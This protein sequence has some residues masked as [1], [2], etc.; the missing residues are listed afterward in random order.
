MVG[1][2]RALTSF[3]LKDPLATTKK[4]TL[5]LHGAGGRGGGGGGAKPL[6]LKAAPRRRARGSAGIPGARLPEDLQVPAAEA[7]SVEAGACARLK[8]TAPGKVEENHPQT[9]ASPTWNPPKGSFFKGTNAS[10]TL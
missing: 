9:A 8:P 1:T 2:L 3:F 10:K 6:S 4:S 5:S 7:R